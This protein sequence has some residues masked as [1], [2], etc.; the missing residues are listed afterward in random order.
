MRTT[1]NIKSADMAWD[2]NGNHIRLYLP[3]PSD[4]AAAEVFVN[5]MKGGKQ[6]AAVLGETK[7][8]RSMSANAYAWALLN[9]L[10]EKLNL[11]AV[12]IYRNLIRD[13]GGASEVVPV[14]DDAADRWCDIWQAR[15]EGWQCQKLDGACL[16]G[17]SLYQCWYGSSVYDKAQMARL[18]ELICFECNAQ[19]IETMTPDELSK[20]KGLTDDE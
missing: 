13:I 10:G 3:S 18:I 19:G 8:N 12:D 9:K 4:K 20:L 15:G 5:D 17:Y 16:S 14:R 2:S 11:P 1:L 6:Y 7:Q